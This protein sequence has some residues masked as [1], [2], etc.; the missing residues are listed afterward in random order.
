MCRGRP[1]LLTSAAPRPRCEA[2][3]NVEDSDLSYSEQ[4]ARRAGPKAA[5]KGA[6]Q[7][8]PALPSTVERDEHVEWKRNSQADHDHNHEADGRTYYYESYED[9]SSEV[10]GSDHIKGMTPRYLRLILQFS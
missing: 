9:C 5:G 7:T 6:R 1:P 10:I 2:R 4:S 3:G 8:S